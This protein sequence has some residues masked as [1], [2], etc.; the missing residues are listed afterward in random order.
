MAVTG[1]ADK[2][3][4]HTRPHEPLPGPLSS[5]GGVHRAEAAWSLATQGQC[6]S[7]EGTYIRISHLCSQGSQ[8]LRSPQ[9]YLKSCSPLRLF[10]ENAKKRRGDANSAPIF[11]ALTSSPHP[12]P[13]PRTTCGP[14]PDLSMCSLLL[15]LPCR[16]LFVNL[17]LRHHFVVFPFLDLCCAVFS[18]GLFLPLSPIVPGLSLQETSYPLRPFSLLLPVFYLGMLPSLVFT[19]HSGLPH[20]T[21]N[22]WSFP[23]PNTIKLLIQPLS[24]FSLCTLIKNLFS[25]TQHSCSLSFLPAA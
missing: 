1:A 9:V 13:P 14:L 2:L 20:P 23:L 16:A 15:V 18:P 7:W 25:R 10:I 11:L 5:C 8:P 19:S 24:S 21:P 22:S 6:R 17:P 3:S 4:T 12:T